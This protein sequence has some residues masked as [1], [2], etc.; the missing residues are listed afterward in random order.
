MDVQMVFGGPDTVLLANT[1][2]AGSGCL[3]HPCEEQER[4]SSPSVFRSVTTTWKEGLLNRKRPFVGR[5]CHSCTPQSQERLFNPS[6]PSLGLRNVIYINETHT[7]HR[8]WLARRLSYVL[9]VL[10]RDVQKDMF[11]RNVVENVLNNSRVES[12]IV[13]V[14]ADGGN[15][16]AE[17]G[18]DPKAASKVRRKAR[19]FLQEMVA[20]ISPAFIRLTGWVLLKL[21]NGFFWSIQIHKGQLEMVKKAASEYNAPLVFLPVHKSHIDYLLITFILFCH[22]I[23]APHIA[24]GNNLNIPI[25]ST[26]IC[27]LGG[28]FIRRKMD[29]TSDGKKDL[30]YR[31]LLHAYTEELLRQQQF[32]EVYLEGTR[33][34]SGK[35]SPARAGMLSIVVETLCISSIP[36]VLIVPVGISYDRIIEGNY[37]SE[38]LGKPKKNESLWGVACGVFR[39]LRKNYGCVRVDFTQPFSLKEYLDT[40]R[41]RHLQAPLTLEQ[42]LLPTIIAAQPDQAVINREEEDRLNSRDLS[43]EPWRRQVIS[44]LAK[45]ILFTAN[46]SSAIM[47]THIVACLLLYRHRNGVLLSKLVEDFFN[48]KEEILSRDFDLGFS[49]NSEDVVMHALSLLGNCVN[50]TSTKRN[51]EFIIAPSNTV[52]ALFELNFYSNGLFHVFIAD[53]I[54][55]CSTLALLREQA[56]VTSE[57][58]QNSFSTLLSQEKLIRRAAGLSHFLSNEVAVALPCQTLYQVFHDA[59]TRL[60]EY[61]ILIVAEEDQE[62]LSPSEEP[63][64]KKFPEA[65]SWRSDEEDEDSDFG[66]EQRDRY[67]KV[68]LSAE[69]Q[70]FFTFLQKI[71]TPVLEAYSGA[72]IFIHSLSSPRSE[73]EYTQQLFRYL[74]T[75]TERGVAAYGESATHYLVKN[76]VKTFKEL[77]VL[78]ER[79]DGAV[80]HLE[81]SSAFLPQA[82]RNKL[83]QYILGFSLL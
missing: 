44:N 66:D 1:P 83:L 13:D 3:K 52:P 22:N 61:G 55:A 53:S 49:G 45:H 24:A 6:I 47:S 59:I 58:E 26:L 56:A 78:K 80:C 31:S 51:T 18:V 9:F 15:V 79:R 21:F 32:L 14:A 5:C 36:D 77:G 38:Q 20:N 33:S 43:D 23:K 72:A 7:R 19:G 41:C 62:E 71:V 2:D 82:N 40:Q 37:N 65:L 74:L 50:V 25:L 46:K 57:S 8:G 12:A 39:M 81:L 4:S 48:M 10:E 70:E 29:E 16:D 17:S 27:K 34:R 63:W 64:P 28:F 68:S 54:I 76:T 60:I 73:R 30:L 69:H 75:R 42:I 35:P 67:L 11:A